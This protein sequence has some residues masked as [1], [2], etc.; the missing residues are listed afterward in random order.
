MFVLFKDVFFILK[1]GFTY[2]FNDIKINFLYM[3]S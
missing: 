1:D 3:F 2:L